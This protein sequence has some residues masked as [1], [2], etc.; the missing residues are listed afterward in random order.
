MSTAAF[1]AEGFPAPMT[2]EDGRRRAHADQ[3][4]RRAQRMESKDL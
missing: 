1:R 4:Q 2:A 3:A